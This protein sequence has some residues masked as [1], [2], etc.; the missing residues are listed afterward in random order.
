MD[1]QHLRPVP[2]SKSIFKG[3]REAVQRGEFALMFKYHSLTWI[4][5]QPLTIVSGIANYFGKSNYGTFHLDEQRKKDSVSEGIKSHSETRFSSS[6]YQV[7]SVH[8]CMSSIK[9]CVD[10]RVLKF[11]TAAVHYQH[12]NCL[13]LST[14]KALN[15]R[16]SY[17]RTFKMAPYTTASWV[18]WWRSSNSYHLV[19][20]QFSP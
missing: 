11:D 7:V 16:R 19:P 12:I 18:R 2:Q 20:T 13:V 15:R 8:T 4:L 1:N 3:F 14:N 5:Y 17:Y 6:Y 9:K 10:Q